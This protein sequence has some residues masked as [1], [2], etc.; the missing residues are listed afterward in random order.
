VRR[1]SISAS[2]VGLERRYAMGFMREGILTDYQTTEPCGDLTYVQ[3]LSFLSIS[4][5]HAP[6]SSQL[7]P[8]CNRKT[9]YHLPEARGVQGEGQGQQGVVGLVYSR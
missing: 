4:L 3:R 9:H 7:F 1:T 5:G 6:A 2:D 8:P